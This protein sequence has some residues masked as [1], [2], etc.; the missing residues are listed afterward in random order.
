[1]WRLILLSLHAVYGMKCRA[2]IQSG[3]GSHGAYESGALLGLLSILPATET[4]YNV[5]V[6]IS[7]GSLNTL[8]LSMYPIGEE[9]AA[10]AY[11]NNTWQT[12]HGIS[13][14]LKDWPGGIAQGILFESALWSSAPEYDLL[15]KFFNSTPVRS[16]SL[17]IMSLDTGEYTS[18]NQTI[19]RDQMLTVGMCSSAIPG[20]FPTVQYVDQTWVDGG[21]AFHMDIFEGIETCLSQGAQESDIIVDMM[22]CTPHHISEDTKSLKTLE[23]YARAMDI[24]F[25]DYEFK[26]ILWA[27]TAYPQVYYRYYMQ[28]SQPLPGVIPLNFTAAALK[29]CSDIG[30]NDSVYNVKNNI[31][32][33]DIVHEN[34]RKMPAVIYAV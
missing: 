24:K 22:S 4:M 2:L 3:G 28:P 17:G 18:F 12:L 32:A 15:N 31:T 21:V 10:A 11:I 27:M 1:M 30:F 25:F 9:I 33:H 5:S 19:G 8:G 34:I 29:E 13:S 20:V 14:I 7:A 23:V 6:G 16:A 26:H